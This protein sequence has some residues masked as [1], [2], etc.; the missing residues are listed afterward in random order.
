MKSTTILTVLIFLAANVFAQKWTRCNFEDEGPVLNDLSVVST[1]TA[2]AVGASGQNNMGM[3]TATVLKTTDEGKNWKN[4]GKNLPGMLSGT[5]IND[6][7]AVFFLNENT[8]WVGGAVLPSNCIFKTDDGG[9]TWEKQEMNSSA[10]VCDIQFINENIGFAC[11][12]NGLFMK[13]TDGGNNWEEQ[14]YDLTDNYY[15]LHFFDAKTGILVNY[16]ATGIQVKKTTDGGANWKKSFHNLELSQFVDCYFIN[17]KVGYISGS[18]GIIIKTTDAG[19]TWT[20]LRTNHNGSTIET[21]C[22][23]GEKTGFAVSGDRIISRTSDGGKSWSDESISDSDG[24]A[25]YEIDF[26]TKK[27]KEE[28]INDE[29]KNV[30]YEAVIYTV[31]DYMSVFKTNRQFVVKEEI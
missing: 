1:S 30:T 5:V 4:I 20:I 18:G 25:L 26:K 15:E 29:Y 7:K 22:F 2:Y 24:A 12:A 23:L 11:G 10:Q 31:G 9:N 13:T 6:L 28:P 21:V 8:G 17:S 16:T 14:T 3:L 27:I 19:E